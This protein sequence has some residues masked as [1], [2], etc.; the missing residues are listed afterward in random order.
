MA[1]RPFLLSCRKWDALPTIASLPEALPFLTT[2]RLLICT[3]MLL[4]WLQLGFPSLDLFF[5]LCTIQR[6]STTLPTSL[7]LSNPKY[8]LTGCLDMKLTLPQCK[9]TDWIME[10]RV[11]KAVL[12]GFS[13]ISFLC[14]V[15]FQP[16]HPS[17]HTNLPFC[18]CFSASWA[19]SQVSSETLNSLHFIIQSQLVLH[20]ACSGSPFEYPK[21]H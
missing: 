10:V 6:R 18:L 21:T 9:C 8:N 19:S 20:T 2:S 14:G 3:R 16:P 15:P 7:S 11:L 13:L 12:Q 4:L 1:S 17:T 5:L